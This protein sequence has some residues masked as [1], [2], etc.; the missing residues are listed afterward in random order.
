M[1]NFIGM[2][3]ATLQKEGVDTKGMSTDEAVKKFNELKGKNGGGKEGGDKKAPSQDKKELTPNERKRLEQLGVENK[4]NT[5]PEIEK[6]AK[7]TG[8]DYVDAERMYKEIKEEEEAYTAF[9][10]KKTAAD[11]NDKYTTGNPD[12]INKQSTLADI[13]SNLQDYK[14]SGRV[15]LVLPGG[16]WLQIIPQKDDTYL[17]RSSNGQKYAG[18]VDNAKNVAVNFFRA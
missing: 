1:A 4:N 17:V 3:F 8:L 13:P 12:N 16:K 5:D 10:D 7:K 15:D 11:R 18:D 9:V 14:G 2:V 6:F